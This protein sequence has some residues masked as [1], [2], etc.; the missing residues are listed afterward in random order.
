MV[1]LRGPDDVDNGLPLCSLHHKLLDKAVLG[2]GDGHRTPEYPC[3]RPVGG[4]RTT[5]AP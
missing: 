1:G 3:S 5:T 4:A 2:I